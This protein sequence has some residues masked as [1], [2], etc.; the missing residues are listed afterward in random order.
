MKELRDNLQRLNISTR[1]LIEDGDKKQKAID[2][3]SY[4]VIFFLYK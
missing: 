3:T 1:N 4:S 2:V